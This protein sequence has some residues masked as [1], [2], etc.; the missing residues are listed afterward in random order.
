MKTKILLL[1]LVA[2]IG[3]FPGA[4][5]AANIVEGGDMET[6]SATLWTTSFLN[7]VSSADYPSYEFGHTAVIPSAGAGGC[8]KVSVIQPTTGVSAFAAYQKVTLT[9]GVNYT[10]DAAFRWADIT[11]ISLLF[12]IGSN[13]PVD[14]ADYSKTSPNALLA[15]IGRWDKPTT[16]TDDPTYV[17]STWN[18]I[19]S[20]PDSKLSIFSNGSKVFTPVT[21]GDYYLVIKATAP[22]G[23]VFNLYIDNVTLTSSTA[24]GVNE[25][26]TSNDIILSHDERIEV[27]RNVVLNSVKIYGIN[28]E[29]IEASIPNANSFVSCKLKTGLY[30]ISIDGKAHKAVVK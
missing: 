9:A 28:G 22:A 20:P 26:N 24:T 14:G 21:S 3:L 4:L 10:L 19:T 13:A 27:K 29:L 7:T 17:A 1:T 11:D 25:I 12:I 23:K 18:P 2:L 5:I 15:S 6:A 30:I 8:L 16:K